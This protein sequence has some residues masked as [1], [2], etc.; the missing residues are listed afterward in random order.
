[1]TT[2]CF[3]LDGTL[4]TNT[5]GA[6]EQAQPHRWAIDRVNALAA[7]G[8]RILIYTARGSS[9]GLD[10]REL[11]EGQLDR[12][13]VSFDEL[14]FGKPTADVFVDDR[15]YQSETWRWGHPTVI[16]GPAFK[17]D[18]RRKAMAHG[19]AGLPPLSE[20]LAVEV[21]RTFGG[22]ALWLEDHVDALFARAEVPHPRPDLLDRIRG[23]VE[24]P[25]GLL[26]QVD[27][28]VFTLVV[29]S[30]M[31]PAYLDL[32]EPDALPGVAV[33]CRPWRHPAHALVHSDPGSRWAGVR[34]LAL[35]DQLLRGALQSDVTTRHVVRAAEAA[36][37]TCRDG[38][39]AAGASEEQILV[40]A[41]FPLL[42]G[43]EPGP[44]A[45]RLAAALGELTG[46][47][48]V[49]ELE[50]IRDEGGGAPQR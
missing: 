16:A 32:Y 9:T 44:N 42:A 12:W 41:P 25:G 19:L 11:T 10:W 3:D 34:A 23:A 8:H 46:V 4:C 30:E 17:D 15:A 43:S 6:Y 45:L 7:A 24:P 36:G 18:A 1:V 5:D 26:G 33:N 28:V 49:A 27:E 29:S 14:S 21:G 35:G 47:D 31:H 37:F 39:P 22:R 13:G 38:A 48:P 2:F 40:C 20:R 50:R